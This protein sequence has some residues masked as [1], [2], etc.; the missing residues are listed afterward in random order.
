MKP[1]H[2]AALAVA[3]LA[4][5]APSLQAQ[6]PEACEAEEAACRA[7]A[8][9]ARVA[10]VNRPEPYMECE[11]N[12]NAAM[13]R[14]TELFHRCMDRL[15]VCSPCT[16]SY[17]TPNHAYCGGNPEWDRCGCCLREESP[18]VIDLGGDGVW[19]SSVDD[20]VLFSIDNGPRR[21]VAWTLF[22]DDAWLALDRNGN[23][24]IGS[25]AELFGTVTPSL[26]GTRFPNGYEALRELDFN[27]DRVLDARDPHYADLKVWRDS[28]RN[29][30]S[31]PWEL[32]SLAA[33]GVLAID[34]D[35]RESKRVDRWGNRFLYRSR[36]RMT[37]GEL[38]RSYDVFP[39]TRTAP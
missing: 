12:Y 15:L 24:I 23:G 20:G 39:A 5:L 21:Q 31:D 38:R 17:Y 7:R 33:A 28:N 22:G 8:E 14:C 36:V 35:Y 27:G 10:C 16:S 25:G 32:Q 29:G 34:L 6:S 1:Y 19:F 18:I 2:V 13:D 26:T 4:P 30:F 37:N 3:V 11:W 9:S